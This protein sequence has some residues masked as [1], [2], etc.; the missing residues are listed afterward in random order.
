MKQEL[1]EPVTE[2]IEAAGL[3]TQDQLELARFFARVEDDLLEWFI[4]HGKLEPSWITALS[5]NLRA[6]K[7][8]VQFTS[9]LTPQDLWKKEQSFF[10]AQEQLPP[11]AGAAA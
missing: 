2:L 11:A 8:L 4:H 6:K 1:V 3:P 9:H 5:Q 7:A 10:A